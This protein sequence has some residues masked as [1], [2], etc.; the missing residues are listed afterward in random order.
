MDRDGRLRGPARQRD[1]PALALARVGTDPD[2]TSQD[3]GGRR[4]P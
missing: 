2:L 4:R 1:V 3:A